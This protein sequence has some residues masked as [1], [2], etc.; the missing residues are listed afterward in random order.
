MTIKR[1]LEKEDLK[2]VTNWDNYYDD[3][4]WSHFEEIIS[5]IKKLDET[6]EI[7]NI[8]EMGPYRTP[9]VVGSDII[10]I[11]R[12]GYPFEINKFI[13]HDCSKTPFPIE[14][15]AYDLVISSQVLEH[16]GL[17]GEQKDIF[18]EIERISRMAIIS[19]PFNWYM[20]NFRS[21]HCIDRGVFDTWANHREYVFEEINGTKRNNKRIIRIYMF[22]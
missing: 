18:N 19:L 10:D 9:F 6:E 20:P 11:K 5:C 4:R 2:K 14:D 17:L 22:K 7:N 16:L 15:K 13:E 12:H 1:F 3:N 21:H 8:L